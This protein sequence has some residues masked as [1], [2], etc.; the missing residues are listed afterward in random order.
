MGLGLVPHF[1]VIL[2]SPRIAS[3]GG[4]LT[5]PHGTSPLT[6]VIIGCAIRV[7][8]V[9]G[10][11][12]FENVYAE[13]LAYEFYENWLVFEQE[14]LVPLV[15]KGVRLN[16]KYYVDFVVEN[17]V[18]VELKAVTEVARIHECQV[19][20]QLKLTALPVGLLIN[21]NVPTLVEGVTRIVNP[22]LRAGSNS[23]ERE[24]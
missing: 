9:I 16:A 7:H 11:G 10:P 8:R 14:R 2:P 21:F 6:K 24:R 19:L 17:R 18:V 3:R 12:V 20:T 1:P 15:Y 23:S 22:D 5:D 4:M 13:C